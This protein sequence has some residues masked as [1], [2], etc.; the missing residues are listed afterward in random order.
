[1]EHVP[2][3][4]GIIAEGH[5]A[6]TDGDVTPKAQQ[7]NG[8]ANGHSADQATSQTSPEDGHALKPSRSRKEEE[9][10]NDPED[11]CAAPAACR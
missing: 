6:H 5:E 2:S 7:I 9:L 10:E 8:D 4:P 11:S 1:M 3:G